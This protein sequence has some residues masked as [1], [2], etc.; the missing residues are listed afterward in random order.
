M[1]CVIEVFL[2]KAD[3]SSMRV[4]SVK[5]YNNY[6]N[7]LSECNKLCKGWGYKKSPYFIDT[8]TNEMNPDKVALVSIKHSS[9]F[10]ED[11]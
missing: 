5:I 8:W 3:V 9:V 11:D 10:D 2:E 1:Y 7:A 4:A 6:D